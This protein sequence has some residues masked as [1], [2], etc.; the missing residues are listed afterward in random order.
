MIAIFAK[1]TPASFIAGIVA[2]LIGSTG[3]PAFAQTDEDNALDEVVVTGT[4]IRRSGFDERQPVQIIDRE[5]ILDQGATN[6]LDIAIYL[7]VN[8]GSIVTQEVGFLVGTSQFNIRGLGTGSTLTLINGRRAG[9]SAVADENGNQFFDINQLPLSMISRI[10][11]QTDGAS[12]T[13]GSE[14]VGGVVNIITRK[15]F[16]GVELQLRAGTSSNEEWSISM[17]SGV[18]NDRGSMNLYATYYDQTQNI[19]GDFDFLE[20]RINGDGDILNSNLLSGSGAPGT[21]EL[22]LLDANGGYLGDSG[23]LFADPDCEAAGGFLR[24]DGRCRYSFFNQATVVPEERRLQAFA[25]LEY[26]LSDALKA[27]AEISYSQNEVERT[28]G[29]QLY[30]NGLAGGNMLIPGDHPFNFFVADGAGSITYIGPD[31]WDNNINV[32]VPLTCNCRPLGA[33]HN[34]DGSIY[35]RISE[36]NYFRALGGVQYDF[37]N[38]WYIDVSYVHNRSEFDRERPYQYIAAAMNSALLNGTFNPFGTRVANPSLVS[39]KDGVSVAGFDRDDF[40]E[41]QY[42]DKVT[43][44]AE[45]TVIDAVIAGDWL[46]VSGGPVGWAFGA[47]YRDETFIQRLDALTASGQ[48]SRP[49][50]SA[51]LI[52]GEQDVY[53]VFAETLLPVT[54]SFELSLAARYEDYGAAGTTTDPKLAARWAVNDSVAFRTSFGTSFQAPSVRQK[55]S[56]TAS[57]FIDDPA[58]VD[59]NGNLVCV[60]AGV[61]QGISFT[62]T[63]S[64][65]LSPQSAKNFNAGIV[66]GSDAFQFSADYWS[67]DYTDLVRPGGSAQSIVSQDCADDGIPNDPRI[68]RESAGAIRS[69][70]SSFINTGQVETD[71]VDFQA[72][73]EFGE[74]RVGSFDLQLGATYVSSFDISN[75]DGT[76][77]DGAGSRNFN[78][79]FSSVPEWKGNVQLRWSSDKHSALAAARYISSYENDQNDTNIDSWTSVDFRYSYSFGEQT[80][81]NRTDVSVGVRN[82]F[83][84]DPPSIGTGT[85]PGYDDRVHSVRGRFVYAELIVGF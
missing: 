18:S 17:A 8:T 78:T 14:A 30:R 3:L 35:N 46:D 1:M 15:G 19:R 74:S 81:V 36:Y 31:A 29:P 67:Y 56:S 6:L 49:D 2:I 80:F 76:V 22:A 42:A 85:R 59:V 54:D 33:E 61:S 39:P 38:D 40:D 69:V 20:E 43:A 11:V 75:A 32:G 4:H 9:K 45:Q 64:D 44:A 12:V 70:T 47:Q 27:Y 79:P 57:V 24:G 10:D 5:D 50:I 63:G 13:Y 84:S 58:S 72:T 83:D 7:P 73:Y 77:T 51:Q 60:N 53:A 52:Q 55:S 16:E 71:G 68:V 23:P 26:D 48:G 21:Y 28:T 41:W 66:F 65:D 62:V 82:A 34:A 37:A 25:E